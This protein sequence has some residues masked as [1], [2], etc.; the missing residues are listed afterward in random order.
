MEHEHGIHQVEITRFH[1]GKL[2]LANDHVAGEDPLELVVEFG[3]L[4]HRNRFTLAITMRTKGSDE[5]LMRGFLLTEGIVDN[6]EDILSCRSA[7]DGPAGHQSITA[8]LSPDVIF[9]R[10]KQ[11]RHF[12]TTSS[13]G[14]CGK[15]SIDMVRQVTSFRPIPGQPSISALKLHDLSLDML[16]KQSAFKKTGGIHA[17]GLFDA[18]LKLLAIEEDVGRHNAVDKLIGS[19]MQNAKLPLNNH[20]LMVS[21]RAGFELVQ[22]AAV[23]G[24]ALFASVGAPSVLAIELAQESDMTLIGFLKD[25]GFNIYSHPERVTSG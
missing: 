6:P 2:V 21:G 18:D 25:T 9:S 8:E 5:S 16:N 14:V 12:Y 23:S 20:I 22:K 4:G 19:A 17:A 7:V 1:D 3:P 10:E 15:T 13:C 24:I 11:Q